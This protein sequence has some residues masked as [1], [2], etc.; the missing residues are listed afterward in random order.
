MTGTEN[1]LKPTPEGINAAIGWS[2]KA[3]LLHELSRDPARVI[4]DK[5]DL[6][7]SDQRQLDRMTTRDLAVLVQPIV[8]ALR[9]EKPFRV[10]WLDRGGVQPTEVEAAAALKKCTITITFEF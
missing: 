7:L 6:S 2:D 1:K 10:V 3:E 9:T 5:L 8:D 4:A